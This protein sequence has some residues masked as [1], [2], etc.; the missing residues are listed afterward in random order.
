[1]KDRGTP[2]EEASHL[3]GADGLRGLA[4]LTV[5]VMHATSFTYPAAI[6]YLT[7]CGK[8]GVWLFFTLSAFLLTVRL[9]TAGLGRASLF[10][11]ALGR[12]LRIYPLFLVAAIA[13]FA[14]GIGIADWQQ[15]LATASLLSGPAHLWTIPIEMAFYLA[16]PAI[17]LVLGTLQRAYGDS[18]LVAAVA[19]SVGAHQLSWP[20]WQTPE[21]SINLAWHLPTFLFGATAA[22][23]R[24]VTFPRDL[25]REALPI[26]ILVAVAL[27]APAVR[28]AIFD[29]SPTRYLMDKHLWMGLA[30]AVV[31]CCVVSRPTRV[32]QW[33]DSGAMIW[34][35][36]VSYSTYLFH[37]I[38]M[39]LLLGLLP[40]SPLTVAV[41]VLWS[42][43]VGLV[44]YVA[45]ER[46]L[47]D[48]RRWLVAP[49]LPEERV[50]PRE[51]SGSCAAAR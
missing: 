29:I 8:I 20:Y 45:A 48:L 30:Y 7:G 49:V 2:A 39:H 47:A 31:I 17:V 6:P 26:M 40:V 44:M 38:A 50:P 1:M 43:A 10:D 12:V 28:Y 33:F 36:R 42:F 15:F 16:L 32:T 23:L 37:W 51:R 11:Y 19:I 14:C 34:M 27:S 9:Q 24:H 41:L 5:M 46:P 21:N 35:G 3:R 13:H 25:A 4:C 22:Y 18:G